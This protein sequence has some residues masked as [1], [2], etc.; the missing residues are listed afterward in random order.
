LRKDLSIIMIDGARGLG[1]G[2]VF[3]AGPLRAP[4]SLQLPGAGAIVVNSTLVSHGEDVGWKTPGLEF[5]MENFDGEILRSHF[6]ARGD[7]AWL[8][9][10]Q[11]SAFA[12]IADP[13]K[14]RATLHGYG[15]LVDVLY[16]YPDHHPLGEYE[17]A[18]ILRE[19]DE[20]KYDFIVTTAKDW[21]RLPDAGA[22][23]ELKRRVRVLD[24]RLE[25]E[26]PDQ[27]ARLLKRAIISRD[28]ALCA[29]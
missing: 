14:F 28:C 13:L 10:A 4:L 5:V 11:I 17:A 19:A 9:G 16:E 2:R 29:A 18:D 15:A 8:D 1:N 27:L 25:L 21:A 26:N 23:G 6:V 22:R 7:A 3:P 24:I 12:G 20:M